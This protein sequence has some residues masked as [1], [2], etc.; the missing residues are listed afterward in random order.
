MVELQVVHSCYDLH[1][2]GDDFSQRIAD[3]VVVGLIKKRHRPPYHT[4][5]WT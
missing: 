2:G 3:H 5:P 4:A 1:L